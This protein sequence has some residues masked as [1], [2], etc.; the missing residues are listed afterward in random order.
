[1][2][3]ESREEKVA[4]P[5]AEMSNGPSDVQLR[6]ELIRAKLRIAHSRTN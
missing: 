3:L 2:N 6:I 4:G 1:M 5:D